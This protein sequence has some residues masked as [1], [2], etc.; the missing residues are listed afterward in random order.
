LIHQ[1]KLVL[2]IDAFRRYNVKTQTQRRWNLMTIKR[3]VRQGPGE[4][5]S[6][7]QM[8]RIHSLQL[9]VGP[10]LNRPRQTPLV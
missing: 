10:Y 9:E 2:K 4:P 8:Q 3:Q 6:G 7:S 1:G 5:I